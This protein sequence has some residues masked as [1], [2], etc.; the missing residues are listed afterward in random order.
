MRVPLLDL[1][2]QYAGLEEELDAALK[3]VCRSG[4]FALGPEVEQFE[5][6]WAAYCEAEHCS[7][8]SS[9]TSALHLALLAVG[10]GP[11]DEVITTPMSFFATV[12]VIL[13]VGAH[14][15]FA[16]IDPQ[17]GNIDVGRIEG[18]ITRR[19]RAILP[20][21]LF[22]QPADM[23]PILELAGQNDLAV[24][25]DACQAHGALYKGRKVGAL[26]DAGAFS[27]YPTKNLNAFG[28]AGAVVTNDPELDARVKMLRNHGQNA[29]YRHAAVGY[30][31]RM[32][33]LQGA[34]LNVKLPH[35]D[36]WNERRRQIARRYTEGLASVPVTPIA[37]APHA[38][39][40]WHVYAMRCEERDGLQ[41]YLSDAGIATGIHYPVPMSHQEALRPYGVAA[42]PG[43]LPEAERLAR[44]TL[45]L[46]LY[47][48]MTDEQVDY[49]IERVRDFYSKAR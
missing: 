49:V 2:A 31:Y 32:D 11:G 4:A 27:Y 5:R 39:A 22:G 36:R 6:S 30:N 17:T 3:R 8:V 41:E 34:V 9:G 26:G 16:D 1:Q 25:E 14:P 45:S 43:A 40:V 44:E 29:R 18:L 28:E 20:V 10:V 24:I 35:L 42:E 47:P 46:P 21:H 48:E 12:E 33:G 23:D 7:G 38:R 13:Y 15:V 19:T 37:E